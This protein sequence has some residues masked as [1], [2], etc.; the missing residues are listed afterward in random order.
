VS[1]SLSAGD[2]LEFDCDCPLG[3]DGV[4]CKHSVAACLAWRAEAKDGKAVCRIGRRELGAYLG[5]QTHDALVELLLDAAD[6]DGR[7]RDRL[8]MAAASG[9]PR[10]ERLATFRASVDAAVSTRGFVSWDEMWDY[11][12]GIDESIDG[13]ERLLG[14]GHADDVVELAEYALAAVEA[15]MQEVDDSSGYMGGILDRLQEMHLKAFRRAKPD[16]RALAE[17]LFAWE[18]NGDWDT[19]TGAFGTYSRV[20]GKV[21]RKRY[22]ELAEEEWSMVPAREPGTERG[23]S[24]RSCAITRIMEAL[25][26]D[27]DELVAVMSRDLASGHQFLRIAAAMRA[28]AI[29]VCLALAH[30]CRGELGATTDGD[31]QRPEDSSRV[32]T[33]GRLLGLAVRDACRLVRSGDSRLAGAIAYWGF[34]AGV[35]WAMLQAFGSPPVLPVLALAYLVG[36]VANTLPIPGSVSGGIAG[37]LIAFGV[38][39][40]LALPSVLAY[41]TVAV[42]LPTP[43]AIAAIPG[44]RATIAG[45][46]REDTKAPVLRRLCCFRG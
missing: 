41:R 3:R 12:S 16:Q 28:L 22:R 24:T 10:A 20:L 26:R 1:L 17:R 40:E 37:V 8:F 25:V 13:L 45:W 29:A 18:L 23:S 5:A 6:S 42:W 4:F 33:A 44:V 11:S 39:A 46:E 14:D 7:L 32:R 19:F 21:G 31:C 38:P 15:A 2:Q 36:Q 30:A 9:G 43:V 35:L 27:V 34:D